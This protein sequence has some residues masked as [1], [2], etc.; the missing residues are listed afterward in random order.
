MGAV[1]YTLLHSGNYNSYSPTLTGIGASG[2]WGI[3]ISGNAA[4]ATNLS[5]NRSTWGTNGTISA[6]V[7]QLSW[8][9]YGNGHTIFDASQSTSP[10]GTAVNSTNAQVAWTATYPTLMGWNGGQTYGVRVDSARVADSAINAIT[11]VNGNNIA[12]KDYV[13][14]KV[15][16]AA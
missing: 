4:T 14:T 13:D 6:V 2:T 9:N 10:D 16:S 5:T 12:T 11:P 3:G 8:K 7:G 1:A 15:A